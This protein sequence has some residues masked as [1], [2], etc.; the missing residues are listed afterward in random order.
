MQVDGDI[1][2]TLLKEKCAPTYR[3][4]VGDELHIVMA[5]KLSNKRKLVL[6]IEFQKKN[7][8]D[9]VLYMIEWFMCIYCRT[10]PWPTVLR[11]WDMFFCEGVKVLFKVALVL[12]KNTIYTKEQCKQYP[13]LH[14]IVTRL[15]NLP[16][17]ITEEDFLVQKVSIKA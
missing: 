8:V 1:L 15:K 16:P 12:L 5:N 13:D 6:N 4:L 11:V 14:S 7:G 2:T 17:S 9:P 3:H 10:L